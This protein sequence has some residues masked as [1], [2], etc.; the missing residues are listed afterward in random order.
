MTERKHN[1]ELE[2]LRSRH[3]REL[4]DLDTSNQSL[5][6]QKRSLE[7]ELEDTMNRLSDQKTENS[8]LRTTISENS[9]AVLTMES[10]TRNLKLKLE[11]CNISYYAISSS[12]L[13][14]RT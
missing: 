10:N 3:K 9:A 8:K 5:Q 13:T 4:D 14:N 6:R 12:V 1:V 2:N 7:Q 11:V